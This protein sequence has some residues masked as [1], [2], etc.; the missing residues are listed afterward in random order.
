MLSE[1]A[2]KVRSD[3]SVGTM[4]LFGIEKV[5]EK[6]VNFWRVFTRKTGKRTILP[7]LA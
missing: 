7:F 2:S 4:S 5:T 3:K 6:V 1:V